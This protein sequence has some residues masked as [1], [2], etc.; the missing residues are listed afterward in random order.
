MSRVIFWASVALCALV[1]TVL[2]QDAASR[3]AAGLLPPAAVKAPEARLVERRILGLGVPL[4]VA[5]RYT[6]SARIRALAPLR[7]VLHGVLPRTAR[8]FIP[9]GAP[10]PRPLILLFHGAKRDGLSL[11]EMWER[12]ANRHGLVLLAPEAQGSAWGN[13]TWA[14]D[15][16]N[17]ALIQ[18][19]IDDL[20]AETP[21]DRDR[22]FLFGHS[23]GA[24]M[25]QLLLNRA[26]G[27]W[28][29][30]VLHAGGAP[31]PLMQPLAAPKPLRVYVGELDESFPPALLRAEVAAP[32]A[33]LGHPTEFL[34]IPDHSHWFYE[35]GPMIA[36]HAWAWMAS[37]TPP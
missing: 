17:P 23:D 27:P 36:E 13:S 1:A 6:P 18:R 11:I 4:P 29:A 19:L 26:D 22:I 24:A 32:M 33:A 16:P 10:G 37:L 35:A 15:S 20:A 8:T 25:A 7:H 31:R 12:T 5:P 30:A 3:D 9:E 21:I 28:R 14:L 34:T 2:H